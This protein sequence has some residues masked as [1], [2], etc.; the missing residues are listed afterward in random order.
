[1]DWRDRAACRSEDPE[2]FFPIGTSDRSSLQLQ[3]AMAVCLT[4]PVQNACLQWVLHGEPI[5]Q[6]AG[7]YGGRDGAERRALKRKARAKQDQRST[8]TSP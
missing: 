4:C 2:L 3:R 6:E 8:A 1:M 7:V 5:G